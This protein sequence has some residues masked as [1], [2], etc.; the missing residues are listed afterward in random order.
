MF[1]V[2][3]RALIGDN[4]GAFGY[5]LQGAAAFATP[6]V[7]GGPE[8]AMIAAVILAGAL[9][10]ALSLDEQQEYVLRYQNDLAAEG[11]AT[12]D[13]AQRFLRRSDH[14]ISVIHDHLRQDGWAE[15]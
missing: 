5:A 15:N 2:A 3:D 12:R 9:L 10:I 6:F 7:E 1:D 8:G 14:A 4:V 13:M 11:W